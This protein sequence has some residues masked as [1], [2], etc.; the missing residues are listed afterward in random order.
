MTWQDPQQSYSQQHQQQP[1]TQWQQ[2]YGGYPNYHTPVARP[3]SKFGI[4][5][6]IMGLIVM[7]GMLALFVVAG[8]MALRANGQINE[9]S[10]E[11]IALG[12]GIIGG[13]FLALIGVIFA[14]VG[15]VN[16][17]KAKVFSVLGL[18][19]NG[20]VLLGVIGMMVIGATMA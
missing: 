11:A 19:F 8:M 9:E 5:S 16:P 12:L 4:A 2:P 1:P 10:P 6:F 20:L 3:H 7:V 18:V 17:S 13:C 14:I 15:L